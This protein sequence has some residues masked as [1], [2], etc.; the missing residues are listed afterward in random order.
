M[1]PGNTKRSVCA[2][3]CLIPFSQPTLFS[4]RKSIFYAC[5][6]CQHHFIAA[7]SI[8]LRPIQDPSSFQK[9][10]KG[11]V[12][13]DAA[14]SVTLTYSLLYT[15]VRA[16][17]LGALHLGRERIQDALRRVV[18]DHVRQIRHP[19]RDLRGLCQS[20]TGFFDQPTGHGTGCIRSYNAHSG[21]R[22]HRQIINRLS[23]PVDAG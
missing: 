19:A 6:N 13:S 1:I 9:A 4:P 14:L 20:Y 11:C 21:E 3:E 16:L 15:L 10:R 12:A 22:M 5:H 23:M 18:P 17:A 7:G 8:R 2:N